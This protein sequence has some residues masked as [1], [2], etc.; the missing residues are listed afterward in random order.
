MEIA[1]RGSIQDSTGIMPDVSQGVFSSN[2]P[3]FTHAKLLQVILSP[4]L[5]GPNLD[6]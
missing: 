4:N 1:I 2:E 3:S 6:T 5:T